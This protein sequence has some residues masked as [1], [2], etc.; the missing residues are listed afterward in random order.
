MCQARAEGAK[1]VVGVLGI[2]SL[3]WEDC[4]AVRLFG[5][6][7]GEGDEADRE[8]DGEVLAVVL[9]VELAVAVAVERWVGWCGAS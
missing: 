2:D 3:G 9:L 4:G 5:P 6:L 1:G 8:R 7:L